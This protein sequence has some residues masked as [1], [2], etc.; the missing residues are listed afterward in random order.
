MTWLIDNWY[1]AIGIIAVLV[2]A[3]F[4]I[5]KFTGLP[6]KEQMVKIKE[7]L[8]FAVVEAEKE[9]GSGTGKIKL[10]MVYSAF[11]TKFP[12]TSKI[13]SFETFSKLVDIA[14]DEMKELLESNEKVKQ[15]IEK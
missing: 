6:N 5:Y 7:W 2:V 9:L 14:L 13:I 15:L 4:A 8:L 1:I 12:I 10:S 3:G 11:I